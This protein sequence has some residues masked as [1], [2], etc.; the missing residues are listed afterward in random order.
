MSELREALKRRMIIA[1][2]PFRS[3]A[4]R[5][6]MFAQ[7]PEIAKRWAAEHP[8]S[9]AGGLP[10]YA[11]N[12]A[13]GS[14]FQEFLHPRLRGKFRDKGGVRFPTGAP[15]AQSSTTDPGEAP[16]GQPGHTAQHP[17]VAPAGPVASIDKGWL[18]HKERRQRK[19]GRDPKAQLAYAAEHVAQMAEK[20]SAYK[21]WYTE[22]QQELSD[23]FDGGVDTFRRILAATSQAATVKS[24]VGFALKAYR[25]LLN[26]EMFKGL[27]APVMAN[28]ERVKSGEEPIGPK[29]GEY[30]KALTTGEGIP[31]DRHIFQL[32]YHTTGTRPS[33]KQIEAAKAQ[34][35]EVARQK[36]WK[37]S[38]VQAALW[39]AHII[40]TNEKA[41]T[42]HH[43]LRQL[44]KEGKLH[45]ITSTGK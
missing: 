21:D 7:H 24:N 40:K 36:G 19:S 13:P 22:C 27:M 6:F 17:A 8:A 3:E 44:Q 5:R 45:G 9:A 16:H 42:Y 15:G 12:A 35:T 1:L 18:M 28:L 31:V 34:I 41:E 32:L 33:D 20:F 30:G 23:L 10:E 29:I 2:N 25:Q 4:Q 37:P 11:G 38:Q 26:G 39:A 43:R 14:K